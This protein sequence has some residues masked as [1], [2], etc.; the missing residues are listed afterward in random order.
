M[1]A[2]KKDRL[3]RIGLEVPKAGLEPARLLKDIG[4]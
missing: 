3:V 2:S 1:F 4:F